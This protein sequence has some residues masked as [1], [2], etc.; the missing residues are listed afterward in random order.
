MC[1]IHVPMIVGLQWLLE[2]VAL[3]AGFVRPTAQPPGMAEHAEHAGR[4]H[5]HYVGIRHHVSQTPVPFQ[6]IE[7]LKIEDRLFFPFL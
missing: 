1:D 2:A 4:A 3:L 6:R 7:R 5:G